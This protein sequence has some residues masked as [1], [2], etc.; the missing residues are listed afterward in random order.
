MDVKSN[1]NPIYRGRA[2]TMED[3]STKA[4][5]KVV[6]ILF[7]T[8]DD[9]LDTFAESMKGV[10][11][12]MG[13]MQKEIDKPPVCAQQSEFKRMQ[14][15]IEKWDGWWKGVFLSV[16]ATIVVAGSIVVVTSST[17]NNNSTRIKDNES[18]IQGLRTT[19]SEIVQTQKTMQKSL[20]DV[21]NKTKEEKDKEFDELKT[22]IEN[23]LKINNNTR[24]T[25]V[26]ARNVN[27]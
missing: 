9:R 21:T 2:V 6:N 20:E 13:D 7:E 10:V 23:A 24:R 12:T 1:K 19:T 3:L 25:T 14:K 4:D 18:A 27:Q 26:R 22:I 8:V 17:A 11:K 15:A 16:L 5:E